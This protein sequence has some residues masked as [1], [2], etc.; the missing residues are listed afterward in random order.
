MAISFRPLEAGEIECR[1]GQI[2]RNGSGLSLLLYK[3]A[4]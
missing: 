1:I 4:Q 2:A 3:D